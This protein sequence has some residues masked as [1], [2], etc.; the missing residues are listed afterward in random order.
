MYLS[1]QENFIIVLSSA[2]ADVNGLR[3]RWAWRIKETLIDILVDQRALC[4]KA[5]IQRVTEDFCQ[6][7]P[8]IDSLKYGNK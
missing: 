8:V 4:V 3:Q 7:P 1:E 6:Q 5:G 2:R